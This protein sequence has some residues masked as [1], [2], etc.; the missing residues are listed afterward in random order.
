PL[1]LIALPCALEQPRRILAYRPYLEHE[2]RIALV[3]VVFPDTARFDHES[4]IVSLLAG[5]ELRHRSC[6]IGDV[7]PALQTIR[8]SRVLKIDNDA[9]SLLSDIDVGVWIGQIDHHPAFVLGA[10]PEV[11]PAQGTA[12]GEGRWTGGRRCGAPR[13]GF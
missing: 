2:T 4:R 12:A 10:P 13:C 5:C 6:K 3:R 7:K 9:I 11:D 1:A 8:Q